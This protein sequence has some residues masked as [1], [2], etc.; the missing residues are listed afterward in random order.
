MLVF[1]QKTRRMIMSINLSEISKK[2]GSK[3]KVKKLSSKICTIVGILLAVTFVIQALFSVSTSKRSLESAI[4]SEFTAIAAQ[5]GVMV[6]SILDTSLTIGENLVNYIVNTMEA[7]ETAA[8]DTPKRQSQ[9]YGDA[10]LRQIA[11]DMED[12]VLNTLWESAGT[13]GDIVGA[14]IFFEPYAFDA[15]VKDYNIYLGSEQIANRTASVFGTYEDYGTS[16]WYTEAIQKGKP[17]IT[18]PYDSGEHVGMKVVTISYPI[19]VDGVSL[20]VILTDVD[21]GSFERI[22]T[23]DEKYDT[24]YTNIINTNNVYVFDSTDPELAGKNMAD[25]NSNN[26]QKIITDGFA[27]GTA[28]TVHTKSV[29]TGSSNAVGVTRYFVPVETDAGT[30][31]AQSVLQASDLNKDANS[32][33]YYTIAIACFALILIIV[34]STIVIKRMLRP[35]GQIE[36][37]AKQMALGLFDAELT[38]VSDDELGVLSESMRVLQ[39]G[40][41][42]V[43]EDLSGGLNAIRQGNFTASSQCPDDYIGVYE[44]IK[45]AMYTIIEDLSGTMGEIKQVADQVNSGSDQVSSAAQA[46]AQGTTEQAASIEHLSETFTALS[47][48]ITQT[49]DFAENAKT[50]AG[51]A[52]S[53]VSSS[54][55]KMDEM[56][57]AMTKISDKSNE[58]GKIIKT[59][60]DIAFQ[61]NILA[62]NAAV[63]SARAGQAGKG[64]AVVA[65]EVRNLA[66]KSTE[67]A[68][69]TT[70]L[71]EDTVSAVLMGTAIAKDTAESIQSV[72]VSSGEIIEFVES[73]ATTSRS[74]ANN[75]SQITNGVDEISSV[76]QTNSATA[77]ESAASSEELSAQ[78]V[79]LNDLMSK[80]KLRQ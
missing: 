25:Y 11:Y 44:P 9:V 80:F 41:K 13:N 4:S 7:E 8:V 51:K 2:N 61:T 30:W 53:E 46:L 66:S 19:V 47:S 3:G 45:N 57:L 73:I 16:A 27:A 26:D 23:T 14:G 32:L 21:M 42:T 39:V 33:M 24:M 75:V 78:A 28:F 60:E 18:D 54:R 6:Q 79:S 74:Q 72:V 36:H 65:D 20:G 29:M 68:K 63:E 62:L 49:A 67:A 71:I 12:F 59:I 58:I 50:S 31:W 1:L 22:K 56:M 38:H 10:M 35:I 43:L 5:N 69:N 48:Q 70:I 34:V 37:A 76:V 15:A 40:T 77:E 17:V 52:R 55:E 64:F